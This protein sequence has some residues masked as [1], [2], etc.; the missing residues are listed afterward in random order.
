MRT[1]GQA[2][3]FGQSDAATMVREAIEKERKVKPSPVVN[4]LLAGALLVGIV[5][6][7]L[8]VAYVL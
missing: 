2:R 8:G 4:M 3:F 1:Q 6:L 7:V 5:A